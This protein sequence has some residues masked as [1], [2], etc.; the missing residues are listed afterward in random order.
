MTRIVIEGVQTRTALI[1]VLHV[2][3]RVMDADGAFEAPQQVFS[4]RALQEP[5]LPDRSEPP[6]DRD[7]A[8]LA[9]GSVHD[10]YVDTVHPHL[11]EAGPPQVYLLGGQT[12]EVR[13]V[14][15]RPGE[16]QTSTVRSV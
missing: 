9:A 13:A 1:E 15:D 7:V 10:R 12:R 11:G 4:S 3:L 2:V 16:V 8:P 14:D 6:V 5:A